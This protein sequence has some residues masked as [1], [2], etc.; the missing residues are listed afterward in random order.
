MYSSVCCAPT[1]NNVRGSI[2]QWATLRQRAFI[3]SGVE[4]LCKQLDANIKNCCKCGLWFSFLDYWD[5]PNS[6]PQSCLLWNKMSSTLNNGKKINWLNFYCTFYTKLFIGLFVSIQSFAAFGQYTQK[7]L[8]SCSIN[9]LY[10]SILLTQ[11]GPKQNYY[12]KVFQ[13]VLR[14]R[15]YRSTILWHHPALQLQH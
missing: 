6:A 3:Y 1:G 5:T 14:F 10:L 9:M 8:F 15:Q 7:Q 13:T 11:C 2:T 4:I 12:V